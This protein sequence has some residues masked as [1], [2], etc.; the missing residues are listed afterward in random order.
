[1]E[2]EPSLQAPEQQGLWRSQQNTHLQ[3]PQTTRI[4]SRKLK[5]LE[6]SGEATNGSMNVTKFSKEPSDIC[7][8]SEL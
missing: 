2:R 1:M 5:M 7:A 6:S 3:N 8:T 4:V